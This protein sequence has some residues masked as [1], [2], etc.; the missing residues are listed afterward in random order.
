MALSD[1]IQE[2]LEDEFEGTL[3][4]AGVAQTMTYHS[5]VDVASDFDPY[6]GEF[7]VS[8]EAGDGA[9][10]FDDEDNSMWLTGIPW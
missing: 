7:S 5:R 9:L 8:E 3:T 10:W 1:D 6:T 2:L 4:D